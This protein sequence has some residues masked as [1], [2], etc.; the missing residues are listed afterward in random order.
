MSLSDRGSR[1]NA[2]YFMRFLIMLMER[3]LDS[4]FM[5]LLC[6]SIQKCA[7]ALLKN[8]KDLYFEPICDAF[9]ALP[10]PEYAKS[11][12]PGGRRPFQFMRMRSA[13]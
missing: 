5:G 9:S 11:R 7:S 8:E 10:C 4:A 3:W 2:G 13:A 6:L 1:R 12:P